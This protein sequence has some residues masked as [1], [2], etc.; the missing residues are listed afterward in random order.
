MSVFAYRLAYVVICCAT[1]I[2]LWFAVRWLVYGMSDEFM[3][4]ALAGGLWATVF[5][6]AA[7]VIDQRRSRKD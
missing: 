2:G 7:H 4:G 6:T 1:M 3:F 5:F